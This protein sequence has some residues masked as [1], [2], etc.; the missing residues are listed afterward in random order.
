MANNFGFVEDKTNKFGFVP[1]N[2]FGFIEDKPQQK[3][4]NIVQNKTQ[5]KE[6][7]VARIKAEFEA[8]NKEIDRQSRNANLRIG[9]GATMQGISA[10]PVF[11]I[12][13]VGTGIGGALFDAGG[14]IMEGASGKDIAKKAGEGFII[15]ET[16]GA[17]PYVGKFAGKT[18]AGQA[19][20]KGVSEGTAKLLETPLAQKITKATA[21]IATKIGNELVK[22]RN[23]V[24]PKAETSVKAEIVKPTQLKTDFTNAKAEDVVENITKPVEVKPTKLA[25]TA[26]LPEDLATPIR[27]SLPEYEVL[28]NKDLIAQASKD[29]TDNP[30]ALGQ[31]QSKAMGEGELSA[32]DFE[33]ARQA[34]NKLYQ[35][36]RFDEALTLTR[37]ISEKAS[38][39]GQSVQA[40]S[41]WSR[42]TPEGA[43]RYGQ[44]IID[45]F[46]K[47][48]KNKIGDLTEEQ[49]LKI[50]EL[51]EN[52]Q[53]TELGTREN[54]V[55]TQL[56][57][58]YLSELVPASKGNQ[59]KTLRN[60]SL[61]LNSKTTTR[62]VLGNA[63]FSN[64]EN[65]ITKPLAAGIDAI[66]S[67]FTGQRTRVA[68]QYKEYFKGL[69]QGFKEGAEDVAM[70]I[71]TRDNIGKRFDLAN[72]A[73]FT[74]NNALKGLEKALNYSLQVPDRAFYQAAFNESIANQLKAAGTEKVTNEIIDRATQEALEAVYQNGGVM[75]KMVSGARQAL[76]NVGT[77][78]FGLGDALIPYAQ[79]PANIVQQSVNYSPFALLKA[80]NNY[81]LGKQRQASLDTARALVGSGLIGT[82]YAATKK[83]LINPSIEDYEVAKNYETLGI[84]P[85][86][87]NLPN[88]SNVSYT[89]L[90]PL[91]APITAG[92]AMADLQAGNPLQALDKSLNTIAD[93]SMLQGLNTFAEDLKRHGGATATVNLGASIPSQFVPSALNQI[94][95]FVDPYSRETY[96][97]N[98][99]KRGLNKA[100]SRIP[101]LSQTLPMRYDV[102]GQPIK[103]Y[104]SE[105]MQKVYDVLFNPLFTNKRV[106][107]STMEK[108]INLYEQTGDKSALLPVADRNIRF[109]D[110]EGN[111]VNKQLSGEDL[112]QYQQQLGV[113]NKDILDNV[114]NTEFYNRLDADQQL[115]LINKVQRSVKSYVDEKLFDKPNAQKRS[116]IRQ[117]TE[118]EKDKIIKEVLSDY[119]KYALP[120]QIKKSYQKNFE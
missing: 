17:L 100:M 78:D 106:E 54:A 12:P 70:G 80:A 94:N 82:G 9:L 27:E 4:N 31:I 55:N 23:V 93:L 112:S 65:A 84:R 34:V 25:Q 99:L 103:K 26:E 20:I 60:I 1:D 118:D 95:A 10:L 58:K 87:I 59:I 64:M 98:P 115:N 117:L 89:Q 73:S 63:I 86:T 101:G 114:L 109:T 6:A 19:V 8:R 104:Q 119:N 67:K 91:S 68:P 3:Q 50:K 5:D 14:A 15:G 83:G 44:Q 35:E 107:N 71:N 48:A 108:L 41:L 56:L 88:G 11:N 69:G 72:R 111:K 36:G 39:A 43:I 32:L 61:L 22:P 81:R 45:D 40:L 96:D 62:N 51:A 2:D 33:T 13:Y 75:G 28:H 42:T 66:A 105:G 16:V 74:G 24:V 77:K 92:S 18:K 53:A 90:Q 120:I 37:Q 7:E 102:T 47:N 38:K 57:M 97:P 76:N 21:P 29:I 110:L 46:N 30:N 52:A 49:M 79:T 116:L 113:I 85:N